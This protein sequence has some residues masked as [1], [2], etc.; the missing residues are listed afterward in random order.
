VYNGVP[1]GLAIIQYADPK[2]ERLSFFGV[3]IFDKGKLHNSPFLCVDGHG[4]GI[5]LTKIENGRPADGS[6]CSYFYRN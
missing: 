6:Y 3:G 1:H 2:D 4:D 5:S